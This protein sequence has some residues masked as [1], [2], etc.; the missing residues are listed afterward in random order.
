MWTIPIQKRQTPKC[1]STKTDEKKQTQNVNYWIVNG[2]SIGVL[3]WLSLFISW[4]EV[5]VGKNGSKTVDKNSAMK[6][7]ISLL[8][9]FRSFSHNIIKLALNVRRGESVKLWFFALLSPPG[10]RS[11]SS[12]MEMRWLFKFTSL[13]ESLNFGE[14]LWNRFT[15]NNHY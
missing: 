9:A 14:S 11:D 3:R 8:F 5:D 7:F 2:L 13:S 4:A 12:L 1:A 15:T 10:G 6:N